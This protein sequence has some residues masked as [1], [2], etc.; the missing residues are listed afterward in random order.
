MAAIADVDVSKLSSR[1]RSELAGM[2]QRVAVHWVAVY[3]RMLQCVAVILLCGAGCC[4]VLLCAAV[5][6]SV[7]KSTQSS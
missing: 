6:C 4:S 7:D 3:C 5:R 1:Q 2:M